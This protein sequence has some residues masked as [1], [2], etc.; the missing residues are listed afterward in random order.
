MAKRCQGFQKYSFDVCDSSRA[1]RQKDCAKDHPHVFPL[2][3][4]GSAVSPQMPQQSA[5]LPERTIKVIPPTEKKQSDEQRY[6][7]L[8]PHKIHVRKACLPGPGGRKISPRRRKLTA[9]N[10]LPPTMQ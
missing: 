8:H 4:S 3:H 2:R 9:C 5:T 10:L 7:V 1:S 6:I